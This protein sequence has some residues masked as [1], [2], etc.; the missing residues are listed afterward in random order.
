MTVLIKGQSEER[1]VTF[2]QK[3]KL[4]DWKTSSVGKDPSVPAASLGFYNGVMA[5]PIISMSTGDGELT[6][7]KSPSCQVCLRESSP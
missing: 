2:G 1:K 5:A 4:P 6:P 3:Y 7:S